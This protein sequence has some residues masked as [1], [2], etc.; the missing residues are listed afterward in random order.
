[1]EI[2]LLVD[3]MTGM[4]NAYQPCSIAESVDPC[5]LDIQGMSVVL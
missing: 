1:M 2:F 4:T 3:E 5:H